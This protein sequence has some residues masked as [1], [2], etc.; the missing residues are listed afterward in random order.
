[1]RQKAHGDE[2]ACRQGADLLEYARS[3]KHSIKQGCACHSEQKGRLGASLAA[4][5]LP[6]VGAMNP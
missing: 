2:S 1:M 6:V 3:Q 5:A 4:A